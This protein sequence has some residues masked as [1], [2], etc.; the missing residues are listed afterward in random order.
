MF[1]ALIEFSRGSLEQRL[2]DECGFAAAGD[3][4]DAG[5]EADGDRGRDVLQVVAARADHLHPAVV[6]GLAAARRDR[7]PFQPCEIFSGQALG[8]AHDVFGRAFG[9]DVPA[10]D[11][12]AR[13]HVDHMIGDADRFLIVLHH[14]HGVA[15][16]AKTFQRFQELLVVAL[17][18][19]DGRLVQ[20]IQHAR[21]PRT[22]LRG[23][24]DALAF[25]ARQGARGARQSEIFQAHIV[26]EFQPRADFLQDAGG[27]FLLLLVQILVEIAEPGIGALD[28]LFADLADMQPRDLHRERFRLQAIAFADVAGAGVLEA[29][30]FLAHPG[31][32]GFLEAA[33]HIGDHAFERLLGFVAAQAIVIDELDFVFARTVQNN[34]AGLLRQVFPRIVEREFVIAAERLQRLQIIGRGGFRPRR[35]GALAQGD[36]LVRH[37]ECG[38]EIELG[39]Q[40]IAG[41]AGAMGIVERKKA[42]LDFGNR[43]TRN[44]A[45]EFR[46]H[47]KL[48]RFALFLLVGEFGDDEAISKIERG[49]DGIRQAVADILLHHDA[50]DHHFDVV[51][52]LLV[53]D[54]NFAD[55]IE[56]AVHLDALEALLLKLREF[57]AVFALAAAHDGGEQEQ[58][59]SFIERKDAIRHLAHGLAFDG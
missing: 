15:E 1:A 26:E 57:L 58:P 20:N 33:L 3:A 14:Q 49:L 10:M 28:R 29:F 27:D 8:R 25:A 40:P 12:R 11:A 5:E 47:Q 39:A 21:Q 9:D 53:E 37:N 50:V 2:D 4:G 35:D 59:R 52:Q 38:I 41:R 32:I 16:I 23:K 54:R 43:E 51:F 18:Q 17:M 55:V 22:D 24:P 36:R 19:A 30:E 45:G 42:R 34:I 31:R 44:G 48:F 7:D 46:R 13:P 56:L 6:H